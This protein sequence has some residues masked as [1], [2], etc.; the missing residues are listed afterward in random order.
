MNTPINKYCVFTLWG[1][2]LSIA[3]QLQRAGKEVI[4]GIIQDMETTKNKPDENPEYEKRRHSI[5]KGVLDTRPA[6][7]LVEQMQ[8]WKDKDEWFV[9][10]DFNNQFKLAD[11]LKDFKYG[12]FPTRFD[13]TMESDRDLAKDFVKKNYPMLTLPETEEFKKVDDA[14]EFINN[15]EE[16][17][18]LKGNSSDAATVVPT[19]SILEHAREEIIDALLADKEDYEKN[20]FVLEQQIRDGI[21]VCVEGIFYH[22]KL[23]ATSIDLEQ[24]NLAA[25]NLS[26]QTGCAMNLVH[27]VPMDCELVKMGLPEAIH[28]IAKKHRGLFFADANIIFKDGIPY[29]LEFCFGR[30]GYD[31]FQTEVTMSGGAD[32]FFD[33][34][35]EGEN[36]FQYCYGAA[37]RG[38]NLKVDHKDGTPKKGIRMRWKPEVEDNLYPYGITKV[39]GAYL[40]AAFIPDVV[41]FTGASDDPEYAAI[42]AY[43]VVKKFSYD[44]LFYRPHSDWKSCDYNGNITDRLEGVQKYIASNSE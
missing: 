6:E 11:K 33:A 39:D 12:L 23:L 41:V 22:G 25:G 10:F 1:E 43:D 16:F 8:N 32:Q 15:S 34:V 44:S 30:P 37:V 28:T 24:K 19:T 2:G 14:I 13:Y 35:V 5:G 40:D 38:M 4:V 27:E 3:W 9:Y 31:S 17:L 36:P 29:F 21:E 42:K 18:A 26:Y 7:T 20:G